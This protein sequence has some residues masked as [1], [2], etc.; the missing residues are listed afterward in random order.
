MLLCLRHPD[1]NRNADATVVMFAVDNSAQILSERTGDPA[2][3][4]PDS[5]I[6]LAATGATNRGWS[7]R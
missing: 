4:P 6:H 3:P 2:Q 1:G 7:T 5:G